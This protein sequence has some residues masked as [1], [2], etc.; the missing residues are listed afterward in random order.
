MV[1]HFL[2]ET[3]YKF[4]ITF[5]FFFFTAYIIDTIQ[6]K[7]SKYHPYFS[8]FLCILFEQYKKE[9]LLHSFF[10]LFACCCCFDASFSFLSLRFFLILLQV[11]SRIVENIEKAKSKRSYRKRN[12]LLLSFFFFLTFFITFRV[13][14]FLP[15]YWLFSFLFFALLALIVIYLLCI[16]VLPR[17]KKEE[18]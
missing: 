9:K 10:A 8:R 12:K 11:Y 4:S 16:T 18:E 15:F 17:S 6:K 2:M 1:F 13:F 5:F 14:L 3:V 7:I